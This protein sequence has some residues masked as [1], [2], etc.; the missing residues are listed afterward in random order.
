[1]NNRVLI[2]RGETNPML[3][4]YMEMVKEDTKTLMQKQQELNQAM[5][6][7][8]EIAGIMQQHKKEAEELQIAQQKNISEMMA[9]NP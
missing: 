9:E 5:A 1:M 8:A 6:S 7:N 4:G 3:M 2:D